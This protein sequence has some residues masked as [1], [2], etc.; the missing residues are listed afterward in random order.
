M[1]EDYEKGLYSPKIVIHGTSL[2][3]RLALDKGG[4]PAYII[5]FQTARDQEYAG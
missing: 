1:G 2:L 4:S 5:H 3:L